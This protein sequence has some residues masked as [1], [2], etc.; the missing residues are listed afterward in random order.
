MLG[1]EV[2][3]FLFFTFWR[4]MRKKTSPFLVKLKNFWADILALP[5]GRRLTFFGSIAAVLF[6]FFPW[7][8]QSEG[9]TITAFGDY[10]LFAALLLVFAVLSILIILREIFSK[11]GYL[12]GVSHGTILIFIL[13]QGLY[14]VTLSTSVFYKMAS[15]I[16]HSDVTLA[17]MFTFLSFG[18]A[19]VGA[20]FSKDYVPE[21][22]TDKK[23]F[24]EPNEV[25]LSS[26]HLKPESQ[27]SLGEYEERENKNKNDL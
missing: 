5:F 14:T 4:F 2:I 18:V 3:G 19:L 6:L 23:I 12:L 26:V 21:G 7:F 16:L 11:R 9:K 24:V 25:D 10:V 27:L 13:F 8:E 15:N 20:I 22:T 17:S 1:F